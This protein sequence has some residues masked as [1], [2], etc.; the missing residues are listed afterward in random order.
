MASH[1][2]GYSGVAYYLNPWLSKGEGTQTSCP[3][4]PGV[5]IGFASGQSRKLLRSGLRGEKGRWALETLAM[6]VAVLAKGAR[7]RGYESEANR[8]DAI[9]EEMTEE[10]RE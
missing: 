1:R 4:L 8:Y 5:W 6:K 7:K 9:L 3:A 10:M 2:C